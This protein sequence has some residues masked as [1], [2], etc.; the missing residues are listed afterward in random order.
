MALQQLPLQF[1]HPRVRHF[2]ELCRIRE[3]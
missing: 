2:I 3:E 1:E